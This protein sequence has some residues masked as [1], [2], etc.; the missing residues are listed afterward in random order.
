MPCKLSDTILKNNSITDNDIDN[1][2]IAPDHEKTI[3]IVIVS[4]SY[5]DKHK[6]KETS[7]IE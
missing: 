5:I 6:H 7:V 2:I 1:S 4:T 3:I